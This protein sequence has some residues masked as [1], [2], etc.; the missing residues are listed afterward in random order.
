MRCRIFFIVALFL[1]YATTSFAET[2]PSVE[3][4]RILVAKERLEVRAKPDKM[5]DVT[6]V[7][8]EKTRLVFEREDVGW[9][10]IITPN[11][12]R[13]WIEADKVIEAKVFKGA[14]AQI[15]GEDQNIPM[16]NSNCS[17]LSDLKEKVD[18]LEERL[19]RIEDSLELKIY[20]LKNN[21]R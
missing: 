12:D 11:G 17:H 2:A 8:V 5:S 13:G 4:R 19:N 20:P 18:C 15:G 14:R 9:I 1:L 6:M 10:Q 7:V 16:R 3:E 21:G